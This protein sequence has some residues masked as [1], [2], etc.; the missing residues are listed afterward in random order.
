MQH[1]DKTT[2]CESEN[3]IVSVFN[4][5]VAYELKF[6]QLSILLTGEQIH[7]LKNVLEQVKEEHW[8]K[9]EEGQFTFF[10][11]PRQIGHFLLSQ[12]EVTELLKLLLEATAMIKV[13]QKLFF[14]ITPRIN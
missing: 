10:L 1:N 11:F 8:F 2:L 5:A 13:H 4:N 6:K 3:G 7:Q 12:G 14:K 9:T